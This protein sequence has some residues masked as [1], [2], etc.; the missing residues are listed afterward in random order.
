MVL[1]GLAGGLFIVPSPRLAAPAMTATQGETALLT[2]VEDAADHVEPEELA[3]LLVKQAQG[4]VVVDIRPP[5]EF[6]AFH[7]RGAVNTA[8]PDL[9]AALAPYKN[10]GRIVLY[11]NGMTHP[12]QARDSLARSGFSNVFLLTDGLTGFIERC[13]K[14]VSLRVE[15]L[16]AADEV[17]INAWR[18]YFYTQTSALPATKTEAPTWPGLVEPAWLAANLGKPGVRVLEVRDQSRYNTAHIPGAV[19]AAPENFRGVVG[20]MSAM[21]LPSDV[22]AAHFSLMGL[23]GDDVVVVVPED[24]LHDASLVCIALA[25]VGHTRYGILDGGMAR[26]RSARLPLTSTIPESRASTYPVRSSTDT[27]TTDYKQVMEHLEKRDAVIIDVR[28]GEFYTGKKVEEARGGHIPGAKNRPFSEDVTTIGD[29]TR[30]KPIDDLAAAYAQLIPSKEATVIVH[31]RTGHQASQTFFVLEHL[32]GY[33]SVLWY[34]A[35]WTEW[36]ARVELPVSQ[37]ALG[38]PRRSSDPSPRPDSIP[39][40]A[41]SKR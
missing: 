6:E 33:R 18:T 3:E 25:R 38:E 35:G 41:S 10:I 15:P 23:E 27:F 19:C 22:L 32:L 12:A 1:I 2:S 16:S 5:E 13:L 28:P 39:S 20:G 30:F 17:K 24:K 8:L 36:A 37:E 34:D 29:V 7:I 14:P 11:S 4:L 21:L 40:R 9:P 31:C 26:W